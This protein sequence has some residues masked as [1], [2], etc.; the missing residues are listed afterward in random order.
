MCQNC[1]SNG[2][3]KG[4]ALS[5]V[6]RV[7][8]TVAINKVFVQE[9]DSWYSFMQIN[10]LRPRPNGPHFTGDI[11]KCISL[12]ENIWTPIIISL[13]FVPKGLIN[14]IPALV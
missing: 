5:P 10:T 13:R 9:V 4:V 12:N 6:H 2:V 1:C 3:R 11:L 7:H 14:N 8:K